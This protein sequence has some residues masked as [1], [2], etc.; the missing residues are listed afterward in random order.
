MGVASKH[1]KWQCAVAP[2]FYQAPTITVSSGKGSKAVLNAVGKDKFTKKGSNHVITN[3]VDAH[4]A[5]KDLEK[6]WNDEEAQ[7]SM[8][9]TT[10]TD[11]FIFEFETN[12]AMKA[13]LALQ[14]ALKAFD[15]HCNEFATSFN[16]AA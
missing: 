4:Q 5:L 16:S 9:V 15:T 6:L 14:Q 8:K 11:H 12:G 13:D 1:T 7:K 2:R 10:K 3:P